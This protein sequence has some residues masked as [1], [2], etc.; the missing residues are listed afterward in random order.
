MTGED[1]GDNGRPTDVPDAQKL[2]VRS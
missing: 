2:E 1:S